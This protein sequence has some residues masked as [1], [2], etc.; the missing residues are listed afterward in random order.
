MNLFLVIASA[1]ASLAAGPTLYANA[2]RAG[3]RRPLG[4]GWECEWCSTPRTRRPW[5]RC[6]ECRKPIRRREPLWW[7]VAGLAGGAAGWVAGASFTLPAYLVF[8]GVTV[9]LTIT[10]LDHKLIPNAI[11][12][13]WGGGA[14]LALAI[15][16]TFDGDVDRLPRAVAAGIGF[17]GVL[18]VVA[19]IARGGFGFGDVKL[20][21][22]L[23]PFVAYQHWEHFVVS[24]FFTG[25]YGGIPAIAMLLFR[26]ARIGDELPYG[27]AMILGAWTALI[28][29]AAF[30][31]LI[32]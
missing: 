26:R 10:D 20:A 7:L 14:L 17:F 5:S 9:M 13:P 24:V 31:E 29:G 18:F 15:G 23:G 27:P 4:W 32:R 19:L 12:Y 22:L 28:G 6:V 1:A 2:I 21:A 8:A 3:S 11:L 16:A 30:I 25:M